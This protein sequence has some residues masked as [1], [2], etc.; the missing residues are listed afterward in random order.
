MNI[1]KPKV[2]SLAKY[3]RTMVDLWDIYGYMQKKSEKVKGN[4]YSR[5][6]SLHTHHYFLAML[7]DVQSHVF[8][9]VFDP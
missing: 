6:F 3:M 2:D 8:F 9:F 5:V 1:L 7:R 4:L